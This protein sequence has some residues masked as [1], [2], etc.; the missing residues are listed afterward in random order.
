MG[1][2]KIGGKKKCKVIVDIFS[3]IQEKYRIVEVARD[4]GLRVKRIGATYRF[5]SIAPEG[6][7]EN[8]LVLYESTNTW[9]DFKTGS[10][11]MADAPTIFYCFYY[12]RLANF[13]PA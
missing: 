9:Y 1:L 3:E 2:R 10:L 11:L 12:Y 13:T 5:D 4:L 7:G 6:D 8:A